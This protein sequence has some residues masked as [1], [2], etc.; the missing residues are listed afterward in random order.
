MKRRDRRILSPSFPPLACRLLTVAADYRREIG[1]V[2]CFLLISL[3]AI[4]FTA[5]I[6]LVSWPVPGID[7]GFDEHGDAYYYGSECL[8]VCDGGIG[9]FYSEDGYVKSRGSVSLLWGIAAAGVLVL[10]K[11]QQ[12]RI[13][14]CATCGYNLTANSS[15]VCPECGTPTS[16]G[17]KV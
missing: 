7:S 16:A 2:A 1:S 11:P 4:S 15:G 12:R 5:L 3:W 14:Y 17:A 9:S 13:G 6:P 8:G 10:W